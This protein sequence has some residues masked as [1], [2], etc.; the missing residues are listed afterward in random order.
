MYSNFKEEDTM[1]GNK[2]PAS[3]L[4]VADLDSCPA[5]TRV[6]EQLL[7]YLREFGGVDR[8]YYIRD[9]E[10]GQRHPESV[11]TWWRRALRDTKVV[12]DGCVIFFPG[13]PRKQASMSIVHQERFDGEIVQERMT[14]QS[15]SCDLV[16]T[17]MSLLCQE[18]SEERVGKVTQFNMETAIITR[19]VI[20]VKLPYS[21][22]N[23][24]PQQV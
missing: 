8:V 11:R 15:R 6:M 14:E 10:D 3:V 20:I 5:H 12:K 24:L 1:I 9:A 22:M 19:R 21:D 23:N 17:Q 2:E 4:V 18:E 7:A 16:D 13:P